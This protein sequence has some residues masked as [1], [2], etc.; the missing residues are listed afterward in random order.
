MNSM[1]HAAD[2]AA[3]TT[4]KARRDNPS[5]TDEQASELYHETYVKVRT[6]A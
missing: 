6:R 2:V 3:R 5:M 1:A 4:A